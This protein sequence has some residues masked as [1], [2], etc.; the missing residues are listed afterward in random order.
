[1]TSF[2][3]LL[4]HGTKTASQVLVQFVIKLDIVWSR[5]QLR[6][7]WLSEQRQRCWRTDCKNSKWSFR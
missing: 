6:I 1:V 7:Q 5:E 2:L 4:S 3:K